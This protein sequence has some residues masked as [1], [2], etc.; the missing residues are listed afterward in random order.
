MRDNGGHAASLMYS[1]NEIFDVKPGET[2]LTASDIG[3]VVGHSFIVYGNHFV[4][5]VEMVAHAYL[6]NICNIYM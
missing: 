5:G 4:L 3:W 1:I 2:M 6:C